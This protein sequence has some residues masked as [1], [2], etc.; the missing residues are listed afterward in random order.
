MTFAESLNKYKLYLI[1][2]GC[3][4]A[5]AYHAII[6]VMVKQWYTDENYSHAFLVP[7]I[8][9]YFLYLRRDSLKAASVSPWNPGLA[10]IILG[11]VQLTFGFLA[12][13]YFTMRSSMIVLL[14]GIVLF[15]FGLEVFRQTLLPLG[16][17]LFMVPLPYIVYNAVAFPLKLFVTRVSVHVLKLIGIVV[18]REG[19]IIMFPSITLEVADACSGMRSLVSLIAL[20][21]AYAFF[22]KTTTTGRSIIIASAVPIAVFTNSL[23]VIVTG[24]L[25]QRWGA[26]AASGFFHEFAGLFVFVVAMAVLMGIGRL[27]KEEGS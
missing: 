13:E 22:K 3:L 7:F 4:M 2:I 11:L 17:L 12:G 6:P 8:A 20:A 18:V 1:T 25:A 14:A 10:V 21:V 16:Y 23:R 9:G 15:L 5:L 26:E 24:V 27:V 19:N